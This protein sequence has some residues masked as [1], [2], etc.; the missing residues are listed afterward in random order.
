[1]EKGVNCH[2]SLWA[3]EWCKDC[4]IFGQKCDEMEGETMKDKDLIYE[5]IAVLRSVG[6]QRK[7]D[8]RSLML[9]AA[10]IMERMARRILDLEEEKAAKEGD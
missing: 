8:D 6:R 2:G 9:A 1:M 5:M 3:G 7:G 10:N 4:P